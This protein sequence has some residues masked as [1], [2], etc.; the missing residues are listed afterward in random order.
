ME[1]LCVLRVSRVT[2]ML[3]SDN[4]FA[5]RVRQVIIKVRLMLRLATTARRCNLLVV[6]RLSHAWIAPRG[7]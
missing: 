1:S 4:L 5:L 3:E 7:L 2:L 6:A